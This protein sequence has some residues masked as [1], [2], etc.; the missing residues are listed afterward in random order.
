MAFQNAQAKKTVAEN[1]LEQTVQEIVNTKIELRG[2]E[3]EY[4]EK[5]N[6]A[7]A[8]RLQSLGTIEVGKGEVAKLENQVSN[9]C[10]KFYNKNLCIKA[11]IFFDKL[12][13]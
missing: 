10:F 11:W 7:E 1:K 2:V 9:L 5:I 3:Q 8:E 6:K 13:T 4:N 12:L